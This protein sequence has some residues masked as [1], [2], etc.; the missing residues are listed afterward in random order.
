MGTA[1]RA[2]DEGRPARGARAAIP[3]RSPNSGGCT[4]RRRAIWPTR[5]AA[6]SIRSC[7]NISTGSSPARTP[8]SMVDRPR[9]EARASARFYRETFPRE[10]R[11]S[12]A[13]VAICTAITHRI[14]VVAFVRV[15]RAHP[16]RSYALLP[17]RIDSGRNSKELA[18][19][20]FRLRP[21]LR[22]GDVGGDHHQQHQGR[23]SWR[24]PARSRWAS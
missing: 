11:R 22:T 3:A 10:F 1:G 8:T 4:A 13:F 2:G 14:S 6:S 18:R 7:S 19:L 12:F 24:S 23:R 21:R 9:P 5:A 15:V 17:K 16:A 20:E